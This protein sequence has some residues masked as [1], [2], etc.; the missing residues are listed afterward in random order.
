M[1]DAFSP[2][3]VERL[4]PPT[5]VVALAARHIES[6][7]TWR[8]NEHLRL[9]SASLIKLPILAA[10]W[11]MAEAGLLDPNERVTVLAEALGCRDSG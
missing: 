11:E 4:N 9:P 7:R 10:F 5:G 2:R 1:T 6:G 8:H 3:L